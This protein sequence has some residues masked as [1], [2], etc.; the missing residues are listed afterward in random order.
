ML[1]P[2]QAIAPKAWPRPAMSEKTMEN[3]GLTF[4]IYVAIIVVAGLLG[5]LFN[6]VTGREWGRIDRMELL[7]SLTASLIAAGLVPLFLDLVGNTEILSKE[8]DLVFSYRNLL[9]FA[10]YC[11]IAAASAKAFIR[12]ISERVLR[13][14]EQAKQS[15][16]EA[17]QLAQANKSL[18]DQEKEAIRKVRIFLDDY[19]EEEAIDSSYIYALIKDSPANTLAEIFAAIREYR[20]ENWQK[21]PERLGKALDLMQQIVNRYQREAFAFDGPDRLFAELGY[22]YKDSTTHGD[23]SQ[24]H[25][26][27]SEAIRYRNDS[28]K[29]R[30]YEFNRALAKVA[31][32]SRQEQPMRYEDREAILEDLHTAI[33]HQFWREA[34]RRLLAA[35]DSELRCWADRH[36]ISDQTLLNENE[37]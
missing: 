16:E 7:R 29:K 23:F 2:E 17:M 31:L 10:G 9:I 8:G 28:S 33:Q 36:Q 13:L 26:F 4:G 24:A 14:S 12:N 3:P 20:T 35:P 37:D 18:R 25:R 22:L 5:G 11:L 15:A 27:L 1:K 30:V 32:V 6:Y 21:H 34:L 19:K